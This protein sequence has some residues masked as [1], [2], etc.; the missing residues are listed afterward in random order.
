[1]NPTRPGVYS[2]E[3]WMTLAAIAISALVAFG[4][5]PAGDAPDIT[6]KVTAIVVAVFAVITNA[7]MVWQ[8]IQAR[9]RLKVE[10]MTYENQRYELPE[11][12][13]GA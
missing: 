11:G 7:V 13:S 5:V 4:V 2:S 6:A 1:M 10:A 9:T 12:D 3:F 8:Y